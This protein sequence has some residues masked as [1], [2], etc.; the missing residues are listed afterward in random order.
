MAAGEDQ[1]QHVV[2][3]HRGL[4]CFVR[5]GSVELDL[6]DELLLLAAKR[7]LA[8]HAVDRLVAPDI[9]QPGPRIAGRIVMRPAF[10]RHRERLLQHVLGEIEI[11]D[12]ADQRRQRPARLVTEYFFDL[13]GV[14]GFTLRC[15][16]GTVEASTRNLEIP[17]L[18]AV[19]PE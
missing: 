10:Q 4:R 18:A 14:M 8:A 5:A 16:S 11:A 7:D 1:P 13:A 15:H 17:G 19:A 9:D 12:E 6:V 2:V 3:E